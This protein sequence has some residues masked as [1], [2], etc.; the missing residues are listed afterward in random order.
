[1]LQDLHPPRFPCEF[2]G[3]FCL[4]N[5]D[6]KYYIRFVDYLQDE[7][8]KQRVYKL[9]RDDP[10]HRV[11]RRYAGV[12]SRGLPAINNKRPNL[13]SY[14]EKRLRKMRKREQQQLRTKLPRLERAFAS[15]GGVSSN[16]R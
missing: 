8:M 12:K 2:I 5:I 3:R 9:P 10:L 6:E 1:M 11:L 4:R 15:P 13:R 16:S 7:V 14:A